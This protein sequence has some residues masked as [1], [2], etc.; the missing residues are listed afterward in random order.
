MANHFGTLKFVSVDMMLGEGAYLKKSED[1]GSY[2]HIWLDLRRR[3]VDFRGWLRWRLHCFCLLLVHFWG[4][5]PIGRGIE[6]VPFLLPRMQGPSCVYNTSPRY[7]LFMTTRHEF[8]KLNLLLCIEMCFQC[9][10]S[11][12]LFL[13]VM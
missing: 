2:S 12:Q 7:V 13:S 6:V 5:F 1:R 10:T 3:K 4:L 11:N 9:T 8:E